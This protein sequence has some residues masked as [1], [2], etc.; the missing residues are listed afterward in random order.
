MQI[1]TPR[2]QII[3][4]GFAAW[5]WLLILFMIAIFCLTALCYGIEDGIRSVPM[6]N[7]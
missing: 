7:L 1:I 5:Q 6:V 3:A 4:D 2:Y